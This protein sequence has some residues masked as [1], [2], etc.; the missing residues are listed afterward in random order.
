MVQELMQVIMACKIRI[1]S[2]QKWRNLKIICKKHSSPYFFC[3]NEGP[4]NELVMCY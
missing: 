4:D 1:Y 2:F 3:V